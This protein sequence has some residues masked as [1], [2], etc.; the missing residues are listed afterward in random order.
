MRGYAPQAFGALKSF[1]TVYTNGLV[2]INTAPVEVISSLDAGITLDMAKRVRSRAGSTP[3]T[4]VSEIRSVAGFETIGFGLQG[5]ITVDSSIYRLFITVKAGE[6]SREVE[7]VVDVNDM[8]VFTGERLSSMLKNSKF[9]QAAQIFPLQKEKTQWEPSNTRR[10][11]RRM[12]TCCAPRATLRWAFLSGLLGQDPCSSLTLAGRPYQQGVQRLGARAHSCVQSGK[13][14]FD[15][16]RAGLRPKQRRV[17][18]VL[19]GHRR[20]PQA[21]VSARVVTVPIKDAGKLREVLPFETSELFLNNADELS[22]SAAPL[23]DGNVV[24][25]AA[26]KARIKAID[27]CL[28]VA[29]LEP[30]VLSLSLFSRHLLLNEFHKGEERRLHRQRVRCRGKRRRPMPL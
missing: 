1:I 18:D 15:L 3:F 30:D 27:D 4:D 20:A 6:A 23:V 8:R 24:A 25:V 22:F 14:L 11:E 13:T 28:S 7:A 29:S 9:E 17:Q 2:N 26:N 5:R 16:F 12:S 10:Q 21:I 19:E